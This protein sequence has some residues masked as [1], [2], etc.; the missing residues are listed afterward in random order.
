MSGDSQWMLPPDIFVYLN[1]LFP[2]GG[3]ILEFGSGDGT[4]ILAENFDIC[5]IEHD[6]IW[7]EKI[8]TECHLIP[9][10]SND[11]STKNNQEGGVISRLVNGYTD[12]NRFKK[13]KKLKDI[14]IYGYDFK[15]SNELK[16]TKFLEAARKILKYKKVKIN[17][18]SEKT[19]KSF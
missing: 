16:N 13:L 17:G 10:I 3:K 9:I 18:I 15:K 2:D 8:D 1:E 7:A 5:S 14:W 11:I 6:E 12:F 19:F 4:R